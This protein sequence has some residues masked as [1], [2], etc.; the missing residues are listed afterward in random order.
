MDRGTNTIMTTSGMAIAGFIFGIL[1]VLLGWIPVLGW[2]IVLL[3]IIF[4]S[5][6]LAQTEK[7]KVKGKGLALAGLILSAFWPAILVIALVLILLGILSFFS[8]L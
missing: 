5:I 6:G 4:S 2:I 8:A 3:G 7:G 1:S